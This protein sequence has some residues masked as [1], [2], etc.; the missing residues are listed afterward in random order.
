MVDYM[1]A[2]EVEDMI[3][4]HLFLKLLVMAVL[5]VAEVVYI[6]EMLEMEVPME[7]MEE[8]VIVTSLLKMVQILLVG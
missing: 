5:M 4:I 7:E 3:F 6:M 1:V 8:E 2:E